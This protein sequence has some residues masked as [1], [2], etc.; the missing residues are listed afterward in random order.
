MRADYGRAVVF[1][2]C[3]YEPR[4]AL[5]ATENDWRRRCPGYRGILA[6][7][8]VYEKHAVPCRLRTRWNEVEYTRLPLQADVVLAPADD[9]AVVLLA[10]GHN[11]KPRL[12]FLRMD[13]TRRNELLAVV[14]F[15]FEEDLGRIALE[16]AQDA[17]NFVAGS[18]VSSFLVFFADGRIWKAT[19]RFSHSSD[20]PFPLTFGVSS[21]VTNSGN[22]PRNARAEK[23]KFPTGKC[24]WEKMFRIGNVDAGELREGRNSRSFPDSIP[25]N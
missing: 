5:K 1:A 3:M 12:V 21:R 13:V 22:L 6:G 17:Y 10:L 20:I 7:L 15:P 18:A 25:E 2:I 24:S 4:E 23:C 16:L 14:E 9:G 8:S 11:G 19:T